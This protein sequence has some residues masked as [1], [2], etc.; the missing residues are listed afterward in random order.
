MP[1]ILTSL[2]ITTLLIATQYPLLTI[3]ISPK[4]VQA[5]LPASE[6]GT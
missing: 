3:P 4:P 6:L 5:Q 2:A 1:R